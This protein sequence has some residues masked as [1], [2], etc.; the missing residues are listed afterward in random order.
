[1]VC[2]LQFSGDMSEI[3]AAVEAPTLLNDAQSGHQNLLKGPSRLALVELTP[4]YRDALIGNVSEDHGRSNW[5][6][7]DFECLFFLSLKYGV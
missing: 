1:M 2:L 6:L 3:S 7:L 4:D 5:V